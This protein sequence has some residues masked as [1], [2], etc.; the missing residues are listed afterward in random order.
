M[1]LSQNS[2]TNNPIFMNRF[3]FLLL[4]LLPIWGVAQTSFKFGRKITDTLPERFQ[5]NTFRLRE[6][7][8]KGIP[9][10]LK[11]GLNERTCYRFAD[12]AAIGLISTFSRGEIYADW[13]ELE[14]YLNEVLQKVMPP[15]L[16]KDSVIHAYLVKDGH[17]NAAMTPFGIMYVNVGLLVELPSEASLAS[18]FTHELAHYYL[19]HSLK[20]FIKEENKD[21]ERVF[22]KNNRSKFSVHNEFQAD[23]LGMVWMKRSPYGAKG[24]RGDMKAMLR[25][26]KKQLLGMED[27]WELTETTHP[28]PERRMAQMD[29]IIQKK[30]D[31]GGVDFLVSQQK[32]MS[33]REGAKSEILRCHLF[34]LDYDECIEKA[35]RFHIQDPNNAEYVYYLL[36]GIR[37][38]CYFNSD[39]WKKKFIVDNY[40]TEIIKPNRRYK[41]KIETNVFA[42]IPTN[43]LGMSEEEVSQ[44]QARFYWEGEVKFETYEQAFDFFCQVGALFEEPECILSNALS[45][46][47]NLELRNSLLKKYLSHKKI[48]NRAFASALLDGSILNSLPN[49]KLTIL[50]DWYTTV[51][52]GLEE[53]YVRNEKISSENHYSNIMLPILQEYP[54]R[55]FL[56]WGTL[57]R[58]QIREYELLRELKEIALKRLINKGEKPTI[59]SLDPRY[60]ELMFQHGVN[61]IE[62]IDFSY[63]DVR[64]GST[65]L[66]SYKEIIAT[67][68][69]DLM[70]EEK[71]S[72]F[73]DTRIATIRAVP[74]GIL[75]WTYYG[76]EGEVPYKQT[77]KEGV[78][79]YLKENLQRYDKELKK[80]DRDFG[81][82][83]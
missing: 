10:E 53:I 35:F 81:K 17:F 12:N 59:Y 31:D 52:Q 8:Y 70:A 68:I 25:L 29:S 6:H 77:G 45:V 82:I 61:E 63:Y 41:E 26:A 9:A 14:A 15:E 48:Q 74:N 30:G 11:T 3:I 22:F 33:F 42:Q 40:F 55:I 58:Y 78:V 73:M 51:R 47:N 67:S 5:L 44:M 50:C 19:R 75:K 65:T 13:P 83:D 60:W 1:V 16:E 54:E 56:D 37:R 38:K 23:S 69:T 43:I 64:K 32:F 57:Q 79:E 36:E 24:V 39:F 20:R 18:V 80:L 72:R 7:I 21:F 71:R 28:V 34:N 76:L 66:E 2:T 4:T 27:T 46:N 62:F 49:K